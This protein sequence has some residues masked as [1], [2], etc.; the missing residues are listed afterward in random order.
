MARRRGTCWGGCKGRTHLRL[1][2]ILR[3]PAELCAAVDET[4]LHLKHEARARGV[5]GVVQRH[6]STHHKGSNGGGG[7]VRT[8]G[9]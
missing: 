7:V 5:R 8:L 4:H 3:D 1:V 6:L 2:R 9:R